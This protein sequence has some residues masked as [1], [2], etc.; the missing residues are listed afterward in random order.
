[1]RDALDALKA[2]AAAE[3]VLLL[4]EGGGRRVRGG[5]QFPLV[6]V[7]DT[8]EGGT[9]GR[10]DE[11]GFLTGG[12]EG[13]ARESDVMLSARKGPPEELGCTPSHQTRRRGERLFIL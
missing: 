6:A 2:L 12:G 5:E 1:M 3:L 8:H 9:L 13:A 11:D 10:G 4:I 7:L